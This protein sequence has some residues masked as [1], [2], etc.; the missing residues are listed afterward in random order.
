[1]NG[2]K[3][4]VPIPAQQVTLKKFRRQLQLLQKVIGKQ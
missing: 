4:V 1:M 2:V 3:A